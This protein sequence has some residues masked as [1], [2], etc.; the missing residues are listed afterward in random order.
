MSCEGGRVEDGGVGVT[1]Y[2][3]HNVA[4]NDSLDDQ[5]MKKIVKFIFLLCCICFR[6]DIIVEK[7]TIIVHEYIHNF[8]FLIA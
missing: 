4:K 6:F 8:Q 5:K 2:G 3:G 7:G 1:G